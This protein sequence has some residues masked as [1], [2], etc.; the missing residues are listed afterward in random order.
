MKQVHFLISGT[1]QGVGYRAFVGRQAKELGFRGQVRNLQDGRVE[2]IAEGTDDLIEE[3]R[4][5]LLKGPRLA[6]VFAVEAKT[7]AGARHF[8]GFSIEED[9]ETPWFGS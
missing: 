3:L 7:I 8:E 5:R 4:I 6:Q 9:G 2:L 1:V